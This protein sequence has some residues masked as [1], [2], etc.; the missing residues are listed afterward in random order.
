[1]IGA[2]ARLVAAYSLFAAI[3]AGVNLGSQWCCVA[4]AGRIGLPPSKAIW[5]ALLVG[6]GTGLVVK[7]VLDKR[8]IF[9]DRATGL[10]AHGQQF[11][12]Y[13]V[14]GLMT[15]AIF[16]GTEVLFSRIDPS[17]RLIYLGGAIGLAIGYVVK[18]ELDRR[19]VFK[20]RKTA[21]GTR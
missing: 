13:S 2:R 6:T 3:A 10:K 16:W 7:Y 21:R 9:D 17:G 12:L 4:A 1:M 14:M 8:F 19:F 18:Y 20:V 15:T 11:S 5:P